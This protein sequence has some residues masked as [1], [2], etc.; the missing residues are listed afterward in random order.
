VVV[1]RLEG[2]P[3]DDVDFDA[4]KFL[5]ILEQP[6]MI[7]KGGAWL[8]V[9]KQVKAVVWASLSPADRAEHGDPMSSALPRDAEDLCA[10]AAQS[11]HGQDVIGH[12]PRVSMHDPSTGTTGGEDLRGLEAARKLD[13]AGRNHVPAT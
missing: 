7:K 9:H 3:R 10:T 13:A 12:P 8:K 2:V 11:L 6:D 4:Q 1:P 5:K